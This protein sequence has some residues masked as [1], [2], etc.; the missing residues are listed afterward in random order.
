[1]RRPSSCLRPVLDLDCLLA[2]HEPAGFDE[3]SPEHSAGEEQH[4]RGK[5]NSQSF[6]PTRTWP[7]F[8]GPGERRTSL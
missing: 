5:H 2:N 7:H 4:D 8:A 1:M 3:K 6:G